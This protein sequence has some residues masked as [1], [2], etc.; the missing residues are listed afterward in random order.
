MAINNA[1]DMNRINTIIGEIGNNKKTVKVIKKDNS[2][3]E[4]SEDDKDKV[5]L[6]EDNRQ[7]LLG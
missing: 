4:R 5:I 2:L 1:N 6:V 7:L 3:L